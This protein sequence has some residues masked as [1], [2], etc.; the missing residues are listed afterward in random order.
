MSSQAIVECFFEKETHTATY[1]VAC[2]QT[3]VCG[4][5]DSVLDFDVPSCSF[6]T[7]SADALISRINEKGWKLEWILET[8]AHADH[9]TGSQYLKQKLGGKVSFRIL[10]FEFFFLRRNLKV[11]IGECIRE[12]QAVFKGIFNMKDLATDGSQF[13][14]LFKDGEVFTI[15]NLSVEVLVESN[16]ERSLISY[17][18]ISFQGD[19]YSWPY[20]SLCLLSYQG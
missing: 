14:H 11:A 3:G 10:L 9:V 7:K 15:G 4:I 17:S 8:H 18:Q 2:P 19:S 20:S 12:T 1:I 16:S 6:S 13:D 5:I